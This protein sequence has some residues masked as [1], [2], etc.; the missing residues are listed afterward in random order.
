MPNSQFPNPNPNFRILLA[1]L[2]GREHTHTLAYNA[3][4]R[5][6]DQMV[7]SSLEPLVLNGGL[8]IPS[9]IVLWVANRSA[10]WFHSQY[11]NPG[12]LAPPN[13]EELITK[14]QLRDY[15]EPRIPAQH[16][17]RP[18][19]AAAARPPAAA[20]VATSPSTSEANPTGRGSRDENPSVDPAFRHRTSD[21]VTIGEAR[22]RGAQRN[23]PVPKTSGGTELCL[24]YHILGFCWT[25][26]RRKPTHRVLTATEKNALKTWCDQCFSSSS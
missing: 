5:E 20:P 8:Y 4:V 25:A 3:F 15:W 17:P 9:K 12:P 2:L 19:P 6:Y 23:N 11:S 22:I 16:L 10:L 7:A 26:C 24:S 14:I 1:A 13:Y 18:T 21:G